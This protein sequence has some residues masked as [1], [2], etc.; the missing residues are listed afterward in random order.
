MHIY[1]EIPG[2]WSYKGLK[3]EFYA[4][5]WDKTKNEWMFLY[6]VNRL[7]SCSGNFTFLIKKKDPCRS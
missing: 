1:S 7:S 2:I 5:H 3:W 6:I 4:K